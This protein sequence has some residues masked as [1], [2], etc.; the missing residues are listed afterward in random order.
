MHARKKRRCYR[1]FGLDF[2]INLRFGR[3]VYRSGE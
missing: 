3:R 2:E 1:Q